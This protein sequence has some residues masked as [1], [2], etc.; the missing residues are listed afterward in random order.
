MER[1]Q[2]P[3][4]D[5]QPSRSVSKSRSRSRSRSRFASPVNRSV[6]RELSDRGNYRERSRYLVAVS[7]C[8]SGSNGFHASED[9]AV[10]MLYRSP[11]REPIS[12]YISGLAAKVVDEDLYDHFRGEGR[13]RRR[14]HSCNNM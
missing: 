4:D 5:A 3:Q 2:S 6:S 11:P 12:L 7:F 1:S 8:I 13:V 9:L 14:F 10:L